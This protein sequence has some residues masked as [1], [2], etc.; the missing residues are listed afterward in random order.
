MSYFTWNISPI[1]TTMQAQDTISPWFWIINSWLRKGGFF[2]FLP[3]IVVINKTLCLASLLSFLFFWNTF[4]SFSENVAK[5]C[6]SPT[7]D[8]YSITCATPVLHLNRFLGTRR[9]FGRRGGG[10]GVVSIWEHKGQNSTET[11]CCGFLVLESRC[12][13]FSVLE[14]RCSGF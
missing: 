3:L 7:I 1:I 4:P 9:G 13:G 14:S 6:W 10:K 8:P 12:R 2:P 5:I 11:R